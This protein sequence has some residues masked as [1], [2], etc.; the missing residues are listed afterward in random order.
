MNWCNS[1]KFS[2]KKLSLLEALKKDI[3]V[4]SR[5]AQTLNLRSLCLTRWTVRHSAIH[6]MLDNL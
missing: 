3:V 6:P 5:E 4:N 1:I 2:P